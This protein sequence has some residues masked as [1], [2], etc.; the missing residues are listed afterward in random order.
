M[1]DG[2]G[3]LTV[4]L[5]TYCDKLVG[6]GKNEHICNEAIHVKSHWGCLILVYYLESEEVGELGK[7]GIQFHKK[8]QIQHRK[9][10]KRFLYQEPQEEAK[11]NLLF[12]GD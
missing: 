3:D 10:A 7:H 4:H 9:C 5:R 1:F 12:A 2:T 8:I 6:V 11:K